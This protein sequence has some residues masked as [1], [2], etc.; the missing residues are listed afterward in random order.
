M[1]AASGPL[2]HS[3]TKTSSPAGGVHLLPSVCLHVPHLLQVCT[4]HPQLRG[5][6]S[7]SSPSGTHTPSPLTKGMQARQ[8]LGAPI[9]V[10]ADAAHQELLV[11]RLD[12]WARAVLPLRHGAHGRFLPLT[13]ACVQ[14]ERQPQGSPC[15]L[16]PPDPHHSNPLQGTNPIPSLPEAGQAVTGREQGEVGELRDL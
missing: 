2:T 5:P 15:S 14:R 10:Q 4:C 3:R 1:L 9:P 13:P 6:A 11:H 16:S 12:L 8:N 7:S